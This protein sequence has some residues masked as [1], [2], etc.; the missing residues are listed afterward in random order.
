[1]ND[2]IH[3]TLRITNTG[4]Q[5]GLFV[6]YLA[7][8]DGLNG[9]RAMLF[10]AYTDASGVKPA[11]DKTWSLGEMNI[12]SAALSTKPNLDLL[13]KRFERN[14]TVAITAGESYNR[15]FICQA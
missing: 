1:M 10:E 11:G 9:L 12:I 3:I 2:N 7:C 6:F 8:Y 4:S 5:P 13:R 14:S 15:S